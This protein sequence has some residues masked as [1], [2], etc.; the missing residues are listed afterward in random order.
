M[1]TRVKVAGFVDSWLGIIPRAKT[2]SS[3]WTDIQKVYVKTGSSTWTQVYAIEKVRY[4]T[5]SVTTLS[6]TFYGVGDIGVNIANISDVGFNDETTSA[7]STQASSAQAAY[8]YGDGYSEFTFGTAAATRAKI[9]IKYKRY[10]S[11]DDSLFATSFSTIKFSLD[12]WSTSSTA[13]TAN[14]NTNDATVQSYVSNEINLNLSNQSRSDL[15]I[16]IGGHQYWGYDGFNEI[17]YSASSGFEIF[18]LYVEFKG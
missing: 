4:V 5:H 6:E 12:N 8:N 16:R 7:T 3:T 13:V 14:H 1:A 18:D 2:A 11:T 15:E 10:G 9:Y 17:Y